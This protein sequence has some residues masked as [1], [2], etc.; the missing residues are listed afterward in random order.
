MNWILV[1]QVA[2]V[3][4]RRKIVGIEKNYIYNYNETHKMLS[5]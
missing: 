5:E 3:V 4:Y 2:F 1:P